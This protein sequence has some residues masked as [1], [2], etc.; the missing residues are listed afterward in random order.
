MYE[1]QY[2]YVKP[3]YGEK[4][5]LCYIDI[6]RFI[7]HIKTDDIYKDVAE[8]VERRFDISNFEIDKLLPKG[9]SIKVIGPM[10]D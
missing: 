9:K 1:F 10:K 8:D 5:K 6:D 4:A 7:V 2:D 3:K